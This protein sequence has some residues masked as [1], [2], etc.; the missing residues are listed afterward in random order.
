MLDS[1]QLHKLDNL[2]ERVTSAVDEMGLDSVVG[3]VVQLAQ[4]RRG[5]EMEQV[6]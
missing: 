5:A 6:I 4:Y 2:L 1:D 3:E